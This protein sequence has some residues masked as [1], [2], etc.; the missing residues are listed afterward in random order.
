MKV[1]TRVKVSKTV[2]EPS[3]LHETV[4]LRMRFQVLL[5]SERI[6]GWSGRLMRQY[7]Q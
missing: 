3:K 2:V 5:L 1:G 7:R 4:A 6:Q